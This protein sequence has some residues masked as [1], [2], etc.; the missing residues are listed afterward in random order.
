MQVP[1]VRDPN[2]LQLNFPAWIYVTADEWLAKEDFAYLLEVEKV[3]KNVK[4]RKSN[5]TGQRE[6]GE[7]WVSI[8]QP[9]AN[10]PT[11]VVKVTSPSNTNV[12]DQ[13]A[14]YCYCPVEPGFSFRTL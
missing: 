4:I 6:S 5:P 14:Y 1:R 8:V 12:N 7:R 2:I 13:S 9:S 11:H 10:F 3:N